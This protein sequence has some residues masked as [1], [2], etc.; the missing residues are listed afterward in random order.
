M[1]AFKTNQIAGVYIFLPPPKLGMFLGVYFLIKSK[2][3][4]LDMKKHFHVQFVIFREIQKTC[5]ENNK[6][7]VER[8]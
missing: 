4:K 6:N 3:Y 1:F 8:D 5:M 7:E 2:K